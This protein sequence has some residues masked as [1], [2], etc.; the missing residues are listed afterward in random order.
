MTEQLEQL[1]ELTHTLSD[2]ARAQEVLDWDRQVMMPAAGAQQRALELAA[3]ATVAHEKLT[4]PALA[5]LLDTL[6]PTAEQLPAAAR[7][8]LR[9]VRR[10]HDR[11]VKVPS[12]LVAE[13]VRVC[14]LAQGQWQ[15]AREADDFPAFEPHL[16]RV[17]EVTR[18]VASAVGGGD[19]YDVLLEDFEPGM[20]REAL[21]P[22]LAELEAGLRSLLEQVRSAGPPA[23]DGVL[24][25][26]YDEAGQE[27][28]VRLVAG[29]M[30]FDFSA[31][32]LDRSAHPFTMGTARDVRITTRYQEDF[33]PSALFGSIHEAGHALYQQGLDPDR[34]RDPSGGY[35]SVGVHE[36]QSR[37]WENMVGRSR[38][39]WSHYLPRLG[40]IFPAQLQGVG[41]DDFLAAINRVEPTLIR[42]E[43]DEVTYNL[44][45]VLR[46]RLETALL[47]GDLKPA[48]LPGAWSEGMDRL[49]GITPGSDREG[50][51]QDIHWAAGVIG[52]FPTYSLGNLLAAQ[53]M[54]TV[55]QDLPDLDASMEAGD[56]APLRT[57]LAEKIHHPGRLHLAPELIQ[58]VTGR[59]LSVGPFLR[60]LK[61]KVEL[62][63]DR[64]AATE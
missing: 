9:E 6:E 41:L 26:S 45:V 25:R 1:Y 12:R 15:Q 31:G 39:F 23:D 62:S 8:D 20:T 53:L 37:L 5:E 56:L 35:C 30:G 34:M 4:S 63:C 7:A 40:E 29:D 50:C 44:H 42:V 2:L 48:E 17:I 51:L 24:R 33:L 13:Q 52:Y 61:Q 43:A 10:S 16:A 22:L 49:L 3:L 38:P 64:I 28:F 60:Y 32:R 21:D 47:S 46:Y 36:S 14:A 18:Q 59:P 58:N 54:E 11:A 55:R 57:W 19:L 27:R